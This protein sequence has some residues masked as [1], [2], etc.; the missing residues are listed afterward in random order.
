MKNGF[1]KKNKRETAE[2]FLR[3]TNDLKS[4]DA[5]VVGRILKRKDVERRLDNFFFHNFF[6]NEDECIAI[7]SLQF[8]PDT[9]SIESVQLLR[10]KNLW[11]KITLFDK[12]LTHK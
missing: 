4:H 5:P 10:V 3:A 2:K 7:C 9:W 11:L 12:I 1:S 8:R 6:S